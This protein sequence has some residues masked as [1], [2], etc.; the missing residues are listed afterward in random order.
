M[1]KIR[2]ELGD[3]DKIKCQ[4]YDIIQESLGNFTVGVKVVN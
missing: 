2:E 4:D 3:D 1:N